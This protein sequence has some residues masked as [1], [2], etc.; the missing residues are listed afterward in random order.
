LLRK[1]PFLVADSEVEKSKRCLSWHQL[2]LACTVQE[3]PAAVANMPVMALVCA[4]GT[5][6]LRPV[7]M[8]SQRVETSAGDKLIASATLGCR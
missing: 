2:L 6:Q 4:V 1:S 7:Q 5:S 3:I 8:L